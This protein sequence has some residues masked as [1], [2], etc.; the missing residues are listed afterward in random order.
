[1]PGKNLAKVG[2]LS[3][4]ETAVA[5]ALEVTDKV[6]VSSDSSEIL[7]LAAS[8]GAVALKR[9]AHL[10][11]DE[12]SSESAVEHALNQLKMYS[13]VCLLM[14]CTSPFTLS[15]EMSEAAKLVEEGVADTVFSSFQ[16][17]TFRW[18]SDDDGFLKPLGHPIDFR[19]RRQELPQVWGETGAFYAFDI[20]GFLEVRYRFFGR[21]K[22][23]PTKVGFPIDIDTLTDLDL[24]R[25]IAESKPIPMLQDR[26]RRI[27]AVIYDFDGVHTDDKV[28][29]DSSGLESVR[30]SRSDGAGV[31]NL[32]NANIAQLIL[33]R[34]SD[35][36]VHRRAEKLQIDCVAPCDDK[37]TFLQK[38]ISDRQYEPHEIAYLGNDTNDIECM[39]RVGVGL[40]VANAH[41][42]VLEKAD[43]VLSH[44][45]GD[46]AI[47]ELAD[48]LLGTF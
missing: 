45:G 25:K 48:L 38:W 40:A 44:D 20:A 33:S 23:I 11:G 2:G 46:G 34:E 24:A 1:M 28:S 47:R 22:H 36:V 8:V 37:W 19:P 10:S 7:N 4:L 43:I 39:E 42:R 41:P 9:P 14:Q 5:T 35:P 12:A 13:G 18:T 16:D 21:V 30:V 17:I 3:L 32:R 29:V 26:L 31:R 27:R 6:C 15:T